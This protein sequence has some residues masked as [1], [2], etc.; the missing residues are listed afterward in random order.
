VFVSSDP[1]A[2]GALRA[3]A[4]AGRRVPDDV[5]VVGF[6]DIPSARYAQPPLTTVRQPMEQMARAMAALAVEQIA[7]G[8][9]GEPRV[10]CPTT[11]VRRDSA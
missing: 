11:L 1:M 10:L 3:L 9:P 5:A 7:G 8:E 2:I 4:A 6:D